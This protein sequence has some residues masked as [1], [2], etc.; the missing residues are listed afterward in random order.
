MAKKLKVKIMFDAEHRRSDGSWARNG[1]GRCVYSWNS[2]EGARLRVDQEASVAPGDTI[3]VYKLTMNPD[4]DIEG[5]QNGSYTV[6]Q[7]ELISEE[8]V[9]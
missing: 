9:A 3:K 2:A 6:A 1:I 5:R 7:R 4:L 8:V